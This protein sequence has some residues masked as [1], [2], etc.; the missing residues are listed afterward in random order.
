MDYVLGMTLFRDPHPY[1]VAL[2]V[3]DSYVFMIPGHH[4]EMAAE[5]AA[6]SLWLTAEN[7]SR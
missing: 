7:H 1:F 5:Y 2:H 6:F 4:G 3:L